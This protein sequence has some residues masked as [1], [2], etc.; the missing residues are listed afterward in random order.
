MASKADIV[1]QF[2]PT[3]L[4]LKNFQVEL[5]TLPRTVLGYTKLSGAMLVVQRLIVL[6]PNTIIILTV[7][8]MV[9]PRLCR[10]QLLHRRRD[11]SHF[12]AAQLQLALPA[13]D[14]YDDNSNVE[15]K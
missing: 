15:Y 11:L 5:F 4:N 6:I 2:P 1:Q 13:G 3:T 14:H 10:S 12:S 7:I 8:I 9:I